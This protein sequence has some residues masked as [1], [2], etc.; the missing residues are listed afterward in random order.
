MS[1]S[2]PRVGRRRFLGAAVGAGVLAAGGY[3][4]W[5]TLHADP[6]SV[7]RRGPHGALRPDPRR[8]LDLPEGFSYRVL[9]QSGRVMSDGLRM[10]FR[11]D[12]MAC[13][14]LPGGALA[15]LRNHENPPGVTPYG[16]WAD[17]APAPE[18]YDPAGMG[19][20]SR[21]VLDP[22]TFEVR[23]S[24][25]VLAGTELNCAGGPSPWGWLSCEETFSPQHGYVFA[26]DPEADTLA[27]PE[28][29]SGYGRFLHE[30]A[31]VEPETSRCT[32]TEDRADGCVY[33]FFPDDPARPF[34]G[35]LHALA[36][37]GRPRFD[38]SRGLSVGERL[39]I[40]WIPLDDPTPDDDTL[41]HE[42]QR[43]GAAIVARGEGLAVDG[44]RGVVMTATIG[45][46]QAAGQIFRIESAGD[47][48]E[49]V[50]LAQSTGRGDF[51]MPDNVVVSPRGGVYFCEDG[52]GGNM[53]RGL[54]AEGHV[55]DFARNALSASELTGVSF[56][57]D[58]RALFLNL[59]TDGLTLVVTGPFAV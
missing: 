28:R 49:L 36:V 20:V 57:P 45:G 48:G 10:P 5:D 29:I 9:A 51:D 30:A 43:R 39:E 18:A 52:L 34:Q 13:F 2:T 38:T 26:C 54:D 19:G 53:L 32:L 12:G 6:R 33:R 16:P 42:A 50:L 22:E 24:N 58:G 44:T 47:G 1:E 27:P 4:I 14:T 23:S 15:L 56:S 11:P 37:R 40:E 35:R 7:W 59:Q 55:F 8:V 31:A 46:P 25:L 17:R 41:R 3:G 21:L